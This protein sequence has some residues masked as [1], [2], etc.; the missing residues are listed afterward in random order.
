M[1]K[2]WILLIGVLVLVCSMSV[3]VLAEE[4]PENTPGGMLGGLLGSLLHDGEL[5]EKLFGEDGIITGALPEGTDLN[6][7]AGTFGEQ[8]GALEAQGQKVLEYIQEKVQNNAG[9]FK[10]DGSTS[11]KLK[12][13]AGGLFDALTGGFGSGGMDYDALD[14]LMEKFAVLSSAENEFLLAMNSKVME[15]GDV[16][17]LS[18]FP[19]GMDDDE[20]AGEEVKAL[21]YASVT[22]YTEDGTV[23]RLLSGSDV[24]VLFTLVWNEES[25]T[26]TVTDAKET[27]DG[28]DFTASFQAM[29]DEVGADL[30]DALL[31]IEYAKAFHIGDMAEFLKDHPEYEGIEFQG[32]IKTA[33]ELEQIENEL[34][35]ALEP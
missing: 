8:F 7:I 33:D 17:L 15:T 21:I 30:N 24:P 3:S 2:R 5:S 25:G 4:A 20:L 23:L 34:C 32:E 11:R 1:K 26:Y 12:D 16:Q 28:E 27:A 18:T 13:L 35:L 14:A 9:S 29:C 31:D 6:K 19:I 10:L 22:N